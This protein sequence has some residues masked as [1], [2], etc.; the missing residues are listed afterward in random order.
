MVSMV[1]LEG[2]PYV[3]VDDCAYTIHSRR[4]RKKNKLQL[5][6]MMMTSAVGAATMIVVSRI[7]AGE[8]IAD[9]LRYFSSPII[10]RLLVVVPR[11]GL[12]ATILHGNNK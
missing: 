9:F 6:M 5:L 11:R 1:R 12:A 10:L 7:Y 8:N 3:P 4:S 2:Q